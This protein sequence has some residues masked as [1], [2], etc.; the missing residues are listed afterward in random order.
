MLRI[1]SVVSVLLTVLISVAQGP[2]IAASNIIINQTSCSGTTISWTNGNGASRIVV[3][4][5]NVAISS[6]PVKN[7]YYLAADSFSNG[8]S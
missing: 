2:T 1:C 3:A 5:K 6:F 8:S 7:T 4:S